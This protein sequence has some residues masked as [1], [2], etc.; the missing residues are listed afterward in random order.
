[1]IYKICCMLQNTIRM[2]QDRAHFMS[3]IIDNLLPHVFNLTQ[4]VFLCVSHDSK[5]LSMGKVR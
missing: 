1:M 3:T 2:A 5:T 4:R